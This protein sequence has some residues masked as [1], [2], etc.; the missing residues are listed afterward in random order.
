MSPET[1]ILAGPL[2]RAEAAGGLDERQD[3][4]HTDGCLGVGKAK[5]SLTAHFSRIAIH[6]VQARPLP[7]AL[8]PFPLMILNNLAL[9]V[10][11]LSSR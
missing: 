1:A 7:M 9:V 10:C 2:L 6:H 3:I 8:S 5:R 11:G 4:G